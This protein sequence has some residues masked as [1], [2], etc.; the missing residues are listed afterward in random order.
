TLICVLGILLFPMPTPL[1]DICLALNIT[2]SMIVMF[3]SLY[4]ARPLDFSSFPALLLVTTLFRLG[5]NVAATRLI[6][7]NGDQGMGAAGSV[8]QAFGE[9]VVGGNY[10]VGV[11]IFFA[12]T[13][14]NLKV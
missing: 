10:V 13:I 8:I 3:A 2:I 7:I 11:V 6:L 5:L 14:V 9:F 12:I 4:M 1:L